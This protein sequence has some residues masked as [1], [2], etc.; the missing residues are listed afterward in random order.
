MSGYQAI[1]ILSCEW[2]DGSVGKELAH[3]LFIVKDRLKVFRVNVPAID[4]P[5]HGDA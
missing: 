3:G 2:F 4:G 1:H 5:F